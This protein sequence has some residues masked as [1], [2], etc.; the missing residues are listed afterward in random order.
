MLTSLK[1]FFRSLVQGGVLLRD[2]PNSR[3]LYG[4]NPKFIDS[5]GVVNLHPNR[6]S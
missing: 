3:R 5:G 4:I 1:L 6:V 2:A